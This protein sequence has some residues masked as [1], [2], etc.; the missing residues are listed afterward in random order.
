MEKKPLQFYFWPTP[1]GQKIAI[2]LEELG[3]SYDVI[4]VDISKGD[5][6]KPEYLALNPN[7]KMPTIVD[8][9]GPGGREIVV[10]ESGAILIYLADKTA[11]FI[12][13]EGTHERYAVLQWLMF[14]MAGFG[15]MLG[16]AHHFRRYAKVKIDYAIE[17]YTDEANRLYGV[18]EKQL[19]GR[20]YVAGDYSIADI[21]LYPWSRTADWQGVDLADYPNVRAWQQRIEARPAVQHALELK[22]E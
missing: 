16:Q 17:R 15:P 22:A 2:M 5:Q 4:P 7:N 18:L 3:M 6:F 20:D 14:Q 13:K 19:D 12:P 10:F 8:P 11:R 1:N 9:D 21:A